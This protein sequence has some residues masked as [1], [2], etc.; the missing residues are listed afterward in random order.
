MGSEGVSGITYRPVFP[1]SPLQLSSIRSES[2][3]KNLYGVKY[4]SFGG[5][6]WRIPNSACV[7]S[8]LVPIG[9]PFEWSAGRIASCLS[10][11]I[12]G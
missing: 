9:G 5:N 12:N 3:V 1:R 8:T 10:M 4:H 6:P 7:P 2:S 11:V